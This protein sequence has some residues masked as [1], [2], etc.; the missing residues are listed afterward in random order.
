MD[1]K[2]E[3]LI[4]ECYFLFKDFGLLKELTNKMK[5]NYRNDIWFLLLLIKEFLLEKKIILILI[6]DQYPKSIDKDN[7]L[8]LFKDFKIFL[9]SNINNNDMK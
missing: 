3:T 7:N 8:L 4:S 5:N 2:I 9:L 1:A 6:F